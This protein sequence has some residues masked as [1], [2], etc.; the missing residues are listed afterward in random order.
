MVEGLKL[1]WEKEWCLVPRS[2]CGKWWMVMAVV[3]E[4]AA[5]YAKAMKF[6]L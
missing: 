6:V 3:V 4:E 2:Y 5:P 1:A